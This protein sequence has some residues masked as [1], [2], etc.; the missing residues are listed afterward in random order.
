MANEKNL[1]PANQRSK[2]EARENSRKG[3]IQSGKSRRAKK[4]L[5]AILK[6]AMPIKLKEL[7]P[8]LCSAILR[9]AQMKATKTNKEM[10]VAEIIMGGMIRCSV[11]GN[12][13][14][15][16]LLLDLLGESPDIKLREREVKIKEA[17]ASPDDEDK[18]DGIDVQIYLPD[19]ERGDGN[20]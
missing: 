8:D 18:G 10:T 20:A 11:K 17:A 3:G 16:K 15:M 12:S 7:P 4:T 13:M 6:N 2:S 5:K 14:M 19:N 1:V 9:A